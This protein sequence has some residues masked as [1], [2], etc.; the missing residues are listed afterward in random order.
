MFHSRNVFV[1]FAIKSVVYLPA[2]TTETIRLSPL[3]GAE[4]DQ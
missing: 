3:A 2:E 1:Y 4:W